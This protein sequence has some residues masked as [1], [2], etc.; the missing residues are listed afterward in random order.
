MIDGGRLSDDT[1]EGLK[2]GQEMTPQR[3][4]DSRREPSD[5]DGQGYAG[6]RCSASHP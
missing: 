5:L 6:T 2:S 1:V 4:V 3:L